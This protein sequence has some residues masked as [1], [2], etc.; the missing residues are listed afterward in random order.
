MRQHDHHAELDPGRY[1]VRGWRALVLPGAALVLALAAA[2]VVP[3]DI[4]LVAGGLL[5]VPG[6]S[7]VVGEH[8]GLARCRRAA[9]RMLAEVPG[10]RVPPG[11]AW[12]ALELTSPRRRRLVAR[13]LLRLLTT[14]EGPPR[15]RVLPVD[16]DA[17]R[18]EASLLLAI[19][20]RLAAVHRPVAP[21]AMLLLDELLTDGAHSPLYAPR[22][23]G[24][25]HA[26]L[27]RV[28]AAIDPR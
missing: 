3:S 9:D 12:R 16:R 13:S 4:G 26:A 1:A 11:V 10:R 2:G 23:E 18:R 22:A 8:V 28:R 7:W 25:L 20:A 19:A 14:V 21:R 27:L 6:L 15:P 5:A 17:V 24:E